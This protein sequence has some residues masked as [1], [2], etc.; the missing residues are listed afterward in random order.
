MIPVHSLSNVN[1]VFTVQTVLLSC[2]HYCL[3]LNT[4]IYS[5]FT[6]ALRCEQYFHKVTV[7]TV[8]HYVC[9]VWIMLFLLCFQFVQCEQW[10]SLCFHSLYSEFSLCFHSLYSVFAVWTVNFHY[11]FT[12]CYIVSIVF[13]IWTVFSQCEHYF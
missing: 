1:N 12:V 13:T 11:V 7:H 9:V 2:E 3:D 10:F 6:I 4:S 5:I 8:F